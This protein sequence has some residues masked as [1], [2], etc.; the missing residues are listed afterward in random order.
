M[1]RVMMDTSTQIA[2]TIPPVQCTFSALP[3]PMLRAVPIFVYSA[4]L[5]Y[6]KGTV[7]VMDHMYLVFGD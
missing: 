4:I 1:M 5:R 2:N 6:N 3:A 7:Q